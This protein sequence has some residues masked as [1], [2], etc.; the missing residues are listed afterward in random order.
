MYIRSF[1]WRLT[2]TYLVVIAAAISALGLY[3]LEQSEQYYTQA[4]RSELVTEAMLIGR[5]V[6]SELQ[7]GRGLRL[8]KPSS[9]PNT[10]L[11]PSL[12][13]ADS[14]SRRVTIIA[15][16]GRVLADNEHD[17]R[18]M[19][20]HRN[21]PEVIGALSGGVRNFSIRYSF[22]LRTNMLYVA[23]AV[24]DRNSP[25]FVARVA[26]P[27][28]GVQEVQSR[29]RNTFLVA[30]AIALILAMVISMRLTGQIA[31]PISAMTAMAGR[32]AKGEFSRRIRTAKLPN[33]EI[34]V[35]ATA[36]NDMSER[37]EQ[38]VGQLS[39][40]RD[41]VETVFR[42]IDD[43]IIV[44]D[45]HG[46]IQTANP[47]AASFFGVAESDI[48]GKPLMQGVLHTDLSELAAKT[49][50][51]GD[52]GSLDITIT[53]PVERRLYVYCAPIA[54]S[55]HGAEGATLVLHDLTEITR[56]NR[57]RRDFVSNVSHELRTPLSTMRA[58]AETVMLRAED[59]KETCV[60]FAGR[61]VGEVER[62]TALVDDLLS[63]AEFEEGRRALITN[64]VPVSDVVDRAIGLARPAAEA[65]SIDL[66]TSGDLSMQVEVDPDLILQALTNLVANAINYTPAGGSVTVSADQEAD[67]VSISV[68]DTGIGIA[69]TEI[70]RIF[71]RFYRV[72][73]ARS[74]ATGGT[75]LG[76]AI[77]KHIVEMH[78]GVVSVESEVGKGSRFAIRLSAEGIE[79]V[80]GAGNAT[81][82]SPLPVRVGE[83]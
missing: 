43:G 46:V 33:D 60:Q 62:L 80:E 76:L 20:N 81:N 54:E 3:L 47:A 30:M 74:R 52:S 7:A 41:K 70:D 23:V 61:L 66:T 71:E 6:D 34:R 55:A 53:S 79:R 83:S 12:R 69:K 42:R 48:V 17:P 10:Q 28:S 13:F 58:M 26:V 59:D 39:T 2:I 67:R 72:D 8:I 64:R 77:A 75:G 57:I 63:L 4:L 19:E 32:I 16:S 18:T 1:R 11:K 35:L 24:P 36:L 73:K 56:V 9:H 15:L 27:L 31:A 51:T 29:I 38:L 22:T 37:L 44:L 21:R 45:E 40:E 50:S 5:V 49:L 68:S 78:G 25:R 82:A 65:K 14:I